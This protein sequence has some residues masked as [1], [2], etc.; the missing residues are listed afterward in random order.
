[1][2]LTSFWLRA[3][4]AA[5]AA[6]AVGFWIGKLT[7]NYHC[8]WYEQQGVSYLK[9]CV[10]L[11][12]EVKWRI[13]A[14]L[15]WV[16]IGSNNELSPLRCQAIIWTNAG[17]LSVGPFG[18]NF[19]EI[20]RPQCVKKLGDAQPSVTKT[21]SVSTRHTFIYTLSQSKASEFNVS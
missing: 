2:S 4:A 19:R 9:Y 11:L 17:I 15:N 6:A 20:S 1:M 18:T 16:I 8:Y 14:S 12:I 3:A 13:Y 7:H 10:P 5:A 21:S